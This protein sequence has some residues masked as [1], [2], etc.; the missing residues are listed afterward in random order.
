M[1]ATIEVYDTLTDQKIETVTIDDETLQQ[2]SVE[3]AEDIKTD[4]FDI[5]LPEM[6]GCYIAKIT[7]GEVDVT[8]TSITVASDKVCWWP[9]CTLGD[10][11]IDLV[12]EKVAEDGDS[13]A[14]TF[15]YKYAYDSWCTE[16]S[17]QICL[18]NTEKNAQVCTDVPKFALDDS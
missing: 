2:Y 17:A 15:N 18:Q 10:A 8:S 16:M 14:W 12:S 13:I 3:A 1:F 6:G 5:M 11:S 9:S 4:L 7:Y